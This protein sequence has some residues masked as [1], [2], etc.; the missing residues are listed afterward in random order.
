MNGQGQ[1]DES[2]LRYGCLNERLT[3]DPFHDRYAELL[4]QANM[5]GLR[6][7]IDPG[8]CALE[9]HRVASDSERVMSCKPLSPFDRNSRSLDRGHPLFVR[10]VAHLASPDQNDVAL[11]QFHAACAGSCL[12]VA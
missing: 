7:S 12:Q 10:P 11:A 6:T 9:L 5:Y 1:A 2:K 3:V 8:G 4:D